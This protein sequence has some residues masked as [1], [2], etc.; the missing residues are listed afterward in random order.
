MKVIKRI[1]ALAA[2]LTLTVGMISTVSAAS[3]RT[4]LGLNKGWYEGAGGKISTSS[5]GFTADLNK[6][7]GWGGVWG[8]QAGYKTK[9]KKGNTYTVKFNISSSKINKYVYIKVGDDKGKKMNWAKWV[10]CKKGKTVSVSET[11]TAKYN[12]N[13][14]AFGFGG[15]YGDRKGVSTD[16]DA[17]YR[18][19]IAPNKKLD[20]RLGKDSSVYTTKIKVTGFSISSGGSSGGSVS[21]SNG[22]VGDSGNTASSDGTVSDGSS[23]GTV[24]TADSTD[25]T[26]STGDYDVLYFAGAAVIAAAAIVVFARK[27][28]SE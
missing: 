22:T 13:E 21:N 16:E 8:G 27:R 9:I 7:I 28:R 20:S 10:D 25:S 14:V 19:S 17:S 24:A 3:W 18:Y 6:Q 1:V 5:S 4:Y 2:V 15:D 26:V 11:F 12:S 23:G